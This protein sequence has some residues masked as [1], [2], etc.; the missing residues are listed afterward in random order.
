MLRWGS[1][2]HIFSLIKTTGMKTWMTWHHYWRTCTTA[3]AQTW[4]YSAAQHLAGPLHRRREALKDCPPV[5]DA[6]THVAQWTLVCLCHFTYWKLT[7]FRRHSWEYLCWEGY[8]IW[9]YVEVKQCMKGE[10]SVLICVQYMYLYN[11]WMGVNTRFVFTEC[12]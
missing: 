11:G 6:Q 8:W 12:A 2:R 7:S 3:K 5:S 1:S 10:L 9:M 4:E